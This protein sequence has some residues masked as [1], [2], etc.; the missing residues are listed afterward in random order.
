MAML[1]SGFEVSSIS[2]LSISPSSW[3]LTSLARFMDL[4]QEEAVGKIHLST[5]LH[6]SRYLLYKMLLRLRIKEE[7]V[8]LIIPTCAG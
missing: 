7:S 1:S 6:S 2:T 8:L 4:Q 5:S 3:S